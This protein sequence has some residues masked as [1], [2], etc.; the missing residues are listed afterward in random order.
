MYNP[1]LDTFIKTANVL[2]FSKAAEEL[3][4]TP[5]AVIKQINA[6]EEHIGVILFIRT[7]RGL[8]LTAAGKELYIEAQKFIAYSNTCLSRIRSIQNDNYIIRIA[9]SSKTYTLFLLDL[10]KI[11]NQYTSG[12]RFKL[13]HFDITAN[14][15]NDNFK[16][17]G[18]LYDIIPGIYD[19][20]NIKTRNC[21]VQPLFNAHLCCA[22]SQTN[23]ISHKNSISLQ[24]LYGKTI[25]LIKRGWN[26][27]AD[28][29]RDELIANHKQINIVDFPVYN[30]DAFNECQ[31]NNLIMITVDAW[32]P[33]H[34]L[35]KLIPLKPS[36]EVPY[37]LMYAKSALK[38]VRQFIEFIK[39]KY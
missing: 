19:E 15:F 20:E 11:L 18:I 23:P 32:N 16:N 9:I 28:K 10:Q 5:P 33:V 24:D 38:P 27:Y 7:H 3:H 8:T 35:L 21:L 31:N 37:G 34:P 29:F 4:L 26:I 14:S 36:Y 1:L 12:L 17:L 2:S 13:I 22:V 30:I 6:F 25:M 39:E